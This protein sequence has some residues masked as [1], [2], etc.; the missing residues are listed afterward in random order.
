M[1]A[2]NYNIDFNG[3]FITVKSAKGQDGCIIDCQGLGRGFMVYGGETA[4]LEGLTV[5]NGDA[6][7]GN[8]GGGVHVVDSEIVI[9]GCVFEN[10]VGAVYC[11]SSSSFFTDCMFADNGNAVASLSSLTTTF[12]NCTFT[13]NSAYGGGAVY[14][15]Q[16]SSTGRLTFTD[17]TFTDNSASEHGGAVCINYRN[18]SS[19]LTF[20]TF[21][22]CMFSGNNATY[23]GGTIY[24]YYYYSTS[25]ATFTNCTFTDNSAASA[26]AGAV[27]SHSNY[28]Y[29]PSLF[30]DC[31]FTNNSS[32]DYGGAISIGHDSTFKNCA[33]T[34]NNTTYGTGGGAV[35]T[36]SSTFINCVFE[37]NHATYG[38]GG[39]AVSTSSSTF[40]DCTFANNA[41]SAN[42]ISTTGHGGAVSTSS[43]SFYYS[44]STFTNCMFTGNIASY[45]G[46]V[47]SSYTQLSIVNCSFSLNEATEQGGAVWCHTPTDQEYPT[48]T[49]LKNCILWDN[50]ATEGSE[51]YE[52]QE[53]LIITYSDIHDGHTGIGNIDSNPLFWNAGNADLHLQHSSP[54][55][56][57]GTMDGAPADDLDGYLRPIGAGC[58]IGAYEYHCDTLIWQGYSSSWSDSQNWQPNM[59]PTEF[60]AVVI[61]ELPDEEIYPVVDNLNSVAAKVLIDSG[62]LTVNLGTLS[63]GN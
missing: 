50:T 41:T 49:T 48:T 60:N 28:R 61:S 19:P 21:D 25:P 14:Y 31:R 9:V 47:S 52:K 46:A 1:G 15:S 12:S 7:E 13:G 10:N 44:P 56:D 51:I 63:I 55:V 58:D 45:G 59:V 4:T 32:S 42:S 20:V 39:G 18:C 29:S 17:C 30:T 6:G 11:S 24:I 53:P 35:F 38:A 8:Y 16:T 33:F 3:K 54:C 57:T 62:I 23:Y 43:P 27:Y 40:T 2:G 34:G 36:I 37:E 5:K 22:N 26:H